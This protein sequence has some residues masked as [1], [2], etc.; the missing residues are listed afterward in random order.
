[1]INLDFEEQEIEIIIKETINFMKSKG[2]KVSSIIKNNRDGGYVAYTNRMGT[3]QASFF[4]LP[5]YDVI[6]EK[7]SN[8]ICALVSM[9]LN[10]PISKE[11]LSLKDILYP[12]NN[13]N[14]FKQFID[15][16]LEYMDKN[17]VL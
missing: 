2:Y 1:M 9:L 4:F 15:Q 7:Q 17:A 10:K 12:S 14:D 3:I 11:Y 13:I 8:F 6:I 5:N 16:S